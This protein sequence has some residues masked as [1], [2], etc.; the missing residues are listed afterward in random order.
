MNGGGDA[1]GVRATPTGLF[2]LFGARSQDCFR[3]RRTCP[4]LVFC[5]PYGTPRRFCSFRGNR[6]SPAG[7]KKAREPHSFTGKGGYGGHR[8]GTW[9]TDQTG[10]TPETLKG[11]AAHLSFLLLMLRQF[12]LIICNAEE[13]NLPEASSP[14]SA[15]FQHRYCIGGCCRRNCRSARSSSSLRCVSK[16]SSAKSPWR[17][18]SAICARKSRRALS[19]C[20][21]CRLAIEP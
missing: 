1:N 5:G 20:R 17:S 10:D 11:H 13:K 12:G 2:N 18:A 19:N 15:A 7:A 6:H 9:L 14:R 21:C 8:P 16:A 4:G 3:R